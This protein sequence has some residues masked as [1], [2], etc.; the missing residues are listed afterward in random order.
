MASTMPLIVDGEDTAVNAD[1]VDD[2]IWYWT[3]K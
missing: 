3:E 1:W 2:T